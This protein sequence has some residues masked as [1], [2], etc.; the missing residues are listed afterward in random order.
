MNYHS[1]TTNNELPGLRCRLGGGGE[2]EECLG[3]G[4]EY[5]GVDEGEIE[6]LQ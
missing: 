2:G 5:K 6:G 3:G 1:R 4:G